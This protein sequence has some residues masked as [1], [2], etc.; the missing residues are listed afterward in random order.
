MSHLKAEVLSLG[1]AADSLALLGQ[2]RAAPTETLLRQATPL[3][4]LLALEQ[5]LPVKS[6]RS[7]FRPRLRL[8]VADPLARFWLV[9]PPANL[10]SLAT[11]RTVARA[12]FEQLFGV[13]ASHWRIEADWAGNRP[14]L[15]CALPTALCTAV[16]QLAQRRG[17]LLYDALPA[18]VRAWN[19]SCQDLPAS[20]WLALGQGSH[21]TYAAIEARQWR[22]VRVAHVGNA[23]SHD[24]LLDRLSGEARRLAVHETALPTQICWLGE[25]GWLPRG[26]TFGDWRSRRLNPYAPSTL[27]GCALQ[28]ANQG[29]AT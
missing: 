5:N 8:T 2:G 25:A 22:Y 14:F 18:F 29:A 27:G 20:T 15:A 6:T 16:E 17:W 11:L 28:L 26:D 9:Q 24:A 13:S 7:L 19:Q 12:R 1:I 3:E 23:P 10:S 21:L 4:N